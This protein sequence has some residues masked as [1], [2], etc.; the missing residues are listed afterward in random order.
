MIKGLDRDE[1]G[2]CSTYLADFATAT[3][4]EVLSVIGSPLSS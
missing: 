3:F 4:S 1:S 2:Y